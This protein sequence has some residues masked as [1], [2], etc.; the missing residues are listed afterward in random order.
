MF[1]KAIW[2]QYI[3]SQQLYSNYSKTIGL[4]LINPMSYSRYLFSLIEVCKEVVRIYNQLGLNSSK[5]C[6]NAE[7]KCVGTKCV[8][9]K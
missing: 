9:A 1:T 5:R 8:G 4:I 2:Y 7:T 3:L 6:Q